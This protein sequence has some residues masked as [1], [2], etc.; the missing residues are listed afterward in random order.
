MGRVV[1]LGDA[2]FVGRPHCG[3]GVT[4][5]AED[6]VAL[7]QALADAQTPVPAALAAFDA[8]RRPVDDH[9]VQHARAL[10]KG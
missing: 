8:Q 7:A 10:G 4:K 6:A 3:M 2:A 1:L 9:V 5:A